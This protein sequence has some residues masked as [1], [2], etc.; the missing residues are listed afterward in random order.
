[1]TLKTERSTVG[2]EIPALPEFVGLVRVMVSTLA[3]ARRAIADD[4]VDDLKL[5]VSEATTNAI[6]SY[7][8]G[9]R[10]G[11]RVFVRWFERADRL[12]VEVEDEG[13]GFDMD[14]VPRHPPVTDATRLNF[15]RG[16]G[17]P[18]IKALVDEVSFDTTSLG[19]LVRLVVYCGPAEE[20]LRL[21]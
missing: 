3:V 9:D 1:M 16:L 18:L 14:A 5:A 15:E 2:F 4:R 20:E 12:E 17:I 19:T 13:G 6:E 7:G 8:H 11:R 21:G 10:S